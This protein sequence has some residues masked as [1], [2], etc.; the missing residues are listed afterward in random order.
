M[1]APDLSGH[2]TH[3][4][5]AARLRTTPNNIHKWVRGIRVGDSRVRLA[6][7][8]VGDRLLFTPEGIEKFLIDCR[9]AKFGPAAAPVR[10]TTP[11]QERRRQAALRKEFDAMIGRD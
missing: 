11:A 7:E 8:V 10:S 1:D 3:R 4:E 6:C 2:L 5:A 9:L